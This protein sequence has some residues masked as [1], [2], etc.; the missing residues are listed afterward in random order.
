MDPKESECE[1]ADWVHQVQVRI[2]LRAFVNI[3]KNK[4]CGVLIVAL[5]S[6]VEHNTASEPRRTHSTS[7]LL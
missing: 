4:N 6:L 3:A 5:C 7:L 2:M 1:V